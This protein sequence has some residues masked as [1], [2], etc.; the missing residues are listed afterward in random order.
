MHRDE[1]ISMT[2]CRPYLLIVLAAMLVGVAACGGSTSNGANSQSSKAIPVVISVASLQAVPLTIN[3]VGSLIAVNSAVIRTQV[4]AQ[5]RAVDFTEGDTVTV[6]QIL[7][8][9]DARPY[10]ALLAQANAN[11]AKDEATLARYRA[12]RQRYDDLMAKDYVSADDY[13]QIK[14]NEQTAAAEVIADQAAVQAAQ[15]NL[16][17]CT[18]RA[19]I[20]GRTGTVAIRAGNLLKTADAATL[21]T[22]TQLD[23]VYVDF[24]IPQQ[25]LDAVRQAMLAKQAVVTMTTS[26]DEGVY[27]HASKLDFIDNT[28]DANSGTVHVRATVSNTDH[29]LWPAQFVHVRLQMGQT[30]PVVTVPT[31]AIGTGP[32]GT[33]VFVVDGQLQVHQRAVTVSRQTAELAIISE[34]LA[35]GEQV[36]SDGQSRL[37]DGIHVQAASSVHS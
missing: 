32:N 19:P 27:A 2:P 8:R 6:G 22:I 5:L 12:Q 28:V 37:H 29:A 4:D 7:F 20:S 14:A 11:L 13:A 33:Y 10:E 21:V 1:S 9:L 18:I 16:D 24:A 25:S 34:G 23:P 26:S 31:T 15:L 36:V 3:A 30:Q 17:Y 35:A